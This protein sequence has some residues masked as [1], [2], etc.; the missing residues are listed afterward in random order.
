VIALPPSEAGADHDRETCVLPAV[1][2][3]SVGA[4]GTVR[5]VADRTLEAGPLPTALVAVTLNE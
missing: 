3:F 5:G 4:S 1:A 2:V